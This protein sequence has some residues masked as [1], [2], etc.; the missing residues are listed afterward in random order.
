MRQRTLARANTADLLRMWL[1]SGK[2]R[3]AWVMALLTAASDDPLQWMWDDPDVPRV[4]RSTFAQR[5]AR[6]AKLLAAQLGAYAAGVP[7]LFRRR[8]RQAMR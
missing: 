3:A 4:V 8:G 7:A 1:L 2:S 5:A 6:V